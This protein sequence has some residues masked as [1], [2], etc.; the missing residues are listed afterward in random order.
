VT[1]AILAA[2]LFTEPPW[3][4]AQQAASKLDDIIA[5]GTL[6]VGSTGDYKPFTYL[7]KVTGQF[8][9]FDIDLAENLGKALGVMVEF[10]PAAWPNL[11]KDFEDGKFDVAM[12][13]ISVTLDRQKKAFFSAPYM[14][15]GKTPI[16]R[17]ENKEKFQTIADIDKPDVKVIT[18]PGGTNERFARTNIKSA[19]IVVH[20]DNT[21]IFDE[22]AKRNADLM[23]TDSSETLYQQKLKPELCAIHPDKPFDFAEKAYLLARDP[24][25][26]ALVDQWLHL[27]QETGAYK[28]VYD[29]WLQ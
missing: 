2:G 9:G 12:G 8:S 16:A 25:L 20:N 29:K 10:V 13:G 23:M 21:T 15:E 22:I 1:G 4:L 14:R 27:A 3:A 26:K 17:C 11:M 5:K 6:R 18:N 28:A 7:D 24:A 19:Q